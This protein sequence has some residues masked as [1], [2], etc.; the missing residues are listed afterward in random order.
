METSG[1]GEYMYL[2]VGEDVEIKLTAQ[3]FNMLPNN[4]NSCSNDPHYSYIQC[5]ETCQWAKVKQKIGCSGPWMSGVGHKYCN[6][7]TQ[8]RDLIVEYQTYVYH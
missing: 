2:R 8:M 6:N 1:R 3:H 7:Y 5:A 4:E